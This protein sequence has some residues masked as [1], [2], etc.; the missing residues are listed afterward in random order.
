MKQYVIHR[1]PSPPSWDFS[2]A[3]PCWSQAETV[4][5]AHPDPS[6]T[7]PFPQVQCKV[8]HD[9]GCLYGL[10]RVQD[11]SILAAHTEY[12][13][14]VF[15]DSCVEFFFR[16]RSDGGYF[17][18]EMSASGAHLLYYVRDWT[19]EGEYYRDFEAVP[20]EDGMQFETRSSLPA[21]ILLEEHRNLTWH[22]QFRVHLAIVEKYLG[23]PLGQLSG[24]R[25]HGN[26]YKCGDDLAAPHWLEWSPVATL[27]FHQ[28]EYFGEFIL[29]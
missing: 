15:R 29:E 27:N 26:F 21:P 28:P 23:S 17:N 13:S 8:L 11:Q 2:W 19:P 16:P 3:S 9:D 5:V 4:T 18:L 12:N 25:W 22:V 6:S 20:P 14:E 24:Q 1:T 10:Y 7:P